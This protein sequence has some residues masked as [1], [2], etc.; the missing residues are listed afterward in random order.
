MENLVYDLR[1]D[2][3]QLA[4]DTTRRAERTGTAP[5]ASLHPGSYWDA[6]HNGLLTLRER[7]TTIFSLPG[8]F[9]GFGFPG[10][11]LLLVWM[12]VS[13]L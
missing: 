6:S 8:V 10:K 12:P 1:Y 7:S 13:L 5:L 2:L 4:A 9:F 3:Y 11:Y